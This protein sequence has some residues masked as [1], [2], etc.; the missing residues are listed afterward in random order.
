MPD[1]FIDGTS[2]QREGE[3]LDVE[4]LR[5]FLREH[6]ADWQGDFVVEQFPRG[7]SNLTYL[8]RTREREVVL[9]RPPLGNVVKTAHDMGRE[10]RVLSRLADVYPLAPRPYV[11][12]DDSD[13]IGAPFYLMERR[14]GVVLRDPLP[15]GLDLNPDVM[16]RACES[17][18]DN[19]AE[20]H[21]VAYE[22]IGLGDLGRPEG[23][24]TR[25][26]EGWARRYRAAE[27]EDV[28]GM[29]EVAGWLAA[30]RP[31]ES[32]AALIHNDYKYDNLLLDP[33]DLARIV[34][35]FDWEMATVGDPLMDLGTT[36]GYW[37]QANDP[38]EL[39][40]H[41]FGPSMLPGNLSRGELISR[42]E[43]QTGREVPT[44]VF[45]YAFGLF[46][47]A[48][49]VQQIY[50]RFVRGHT[51]DARFARLNRVVAAL[52]RQAAAAVEGDRV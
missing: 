9:R 49:I 21:G 15:S 36:L 48:V 13:V 17:L 10:Y 45:Y 11:Y 23:Y 52:A 1:R 34:A 41:T 27:T 7:F 44:P 31:A 33:G 20:L 12:C 16:R 5:V 51:A 24:I 18:I 4:R 39:H 6:L 43:A 35:V 3:Q 38:E 25:Q 32:G 8:I 28:P 29:D 46:K 2:P 47:I 14:C 26:V 37:I 30:N 50:A 19:L 22:S 40:E 42:Y